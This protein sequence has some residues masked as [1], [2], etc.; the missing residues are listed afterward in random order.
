[1]T[2]FAATLVISFIVI[3]GAMFWLSHSKRRH[4][5]G[6]HGLTGMCHED[7][8][9]VCNSCAGLASVPS[10][11]ACRGGGTAGEKAPAI[12]VEA[13]NGEGPVGKDRG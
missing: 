7:G 5:H 4:R 6:K 3:V 12:G 13:V 9:A 1:M 2:T 10:Q 8:G 11:G